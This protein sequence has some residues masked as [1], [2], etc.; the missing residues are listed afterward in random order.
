[1]KQILLTSSVLILAIL[2]IRWILRKR[3]SKRLIYATW[4]LVALRLL[5]PFQFGH[6]EYSV[7]AVTEKLEQRSESIQQLEQTFQEPVAGPSRE[8]LYQQTLQNYHEQTQ[9][10]QPDSQEHMQ[11]SPSQPTQ[12]VTPE[13]HAEIQQE[14]EQTITAPTPKQL[15]TTLWIAGIIGMAV[16][17]LVTNILFLRRVKR[18]ATACKDI[19]AP[20]PI[21]ISPNVTTPCLAGL[22]RPVIYLTPDSASDPQKQ[23]H[24]LTHELTHLRHWD[25]I[26]SWVRCL[27]LCVY[28]FNPLVWIAAMVSKRDCE[29]A[30]DEAALR[31]LGDAERIA[32]GKTL[33]DTV[34]HS[35][36]HILQTTTAMAETKKQLKER[37]NYIVKK[38]KTLWIAVIAL[39]VAVT[40][41]AGLVFTGCKQQNTNP[42]DTSPTTGKSD[43]TEDTPDILTEESI[44][45][46]LEQASQIVEDN[47]TITLKA[48]WVTEDYL[49]FVNPLSQLVTIGDDAITITPGY[50]TSWTKTFVYATFLDL[51]TDKYADDITPRDI[52]YDETFDRLFIHEIFLYTGWREAGYD[53]IK[54]CFAAIDAG[55]LEMPQDAFY[56][57]YRD[58]SIRPAC[59]SDRDIFEIFFPST[60]EPNPAETEALSTAENIIYLY[61]SYRSID[62]CCEYELLD[63]DMTQYLTDT[64]RKGYNGQQY[65]LKCCHTADEVCAHIDRVM[66]SSLQRSYPTD[67][68]FTDGQALYLT[69]PRDSVH[70]YYTDV[71][72]SSFS[73][74]YI[75]ATANI[76]DEDGISGIAD[77][78]I[79]ITDTGAKI[80]QVQISDPPPHNHNF[81]VTTVAP[82]CTEEG[83]DLHKCELCGHFFHDNFTE[84][85]PHRYQSSTVAPTCSEKGHTLYK[86][87]NCDHSYKDDFSEK[88]EHSYKS[89]T[90]KPTC[91]DKGYDLHQCD[92]GESYK[93]N[94]TSATGHDYR[95]D[96]SKYFDQATTVK[97]GFCYMTCKNC[98]DSYRKTLVASEGIDLETLVAECEDYARS[99][100][101]N[102]VA[103]EDY[104]YSTNY[105]KTNSVATLYL[106]LG[107]ENPPELLKQ[108]IINM[109][110]HAADNTAE[111]NFGPDHYYMYIRVNLH[112]S[113]SLTNEYYFTVAYGT[114]N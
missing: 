89:S 107:L 71:Q 61:S 83:Y 21:R 111:G 64:Q 53:S 73:D 81:V 109:I 60:P 70:T 90:V 11:P 15:L 38:Q 102:V 44:L 78:H 7:V 58:P 31:K 92:C 5:I 13:V 103:Y 18:S 52:H 22:I 96:D 55:E 16:W 2:L 3:V 36:V 57:N 30:C 75:K 93:D 104:D 9:Q 80:S 112:Y 77:F 33:L 99:L 56:I 62:V 106:C 32:Y 51:L 86:C 100:G 68:L 105:S 72:I 1:M 50:D 101:F 114:P 88:L 65:R 28:W 79:E 20:I 19:T 10:T 6:S 37:V 95:T 76:R 43:S 14:V 91:T 46:L 69:L 94:Y 4:L 85:I 35:P 63:E 59:N 49:N 48:H 97:N 41:T 27:C 42:P 87:N 82:T 12:T 110:N 67:K 25:H 54:D 17:F 74:T 26:W 84:R 45:Q 29:L 23:E 34:T 113:L 66:D 47:A 39:I 40:V 8:E 24:V 98:K 108:R